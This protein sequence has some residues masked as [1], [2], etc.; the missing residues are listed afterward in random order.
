ML[1]DLSK[2]YGDCVSDEGAV[3][4][5][6]WA[7]VRWGPIV[8]PY[9]ASLHRV[10]G[11]ASHERHTLL[12]CPAP[13]RREGELCWDA[14][15]LGV[16]AV[17][18][19]RV[20]GHSETLARG[21]EGAIVWECWAPSAECRIA[22]ADGSLMAGLGYVEHIQVSIRPWQLPFDEL[23][24][25]RFVSDDEALTWI[26]WLGRPARRWVFRNGKE[27]DV[28]SVG[29]DRIDLPGDG[30]AL[31]LTDPI[32]LRD[33]RLLSGAL[34]AVPV[35]PLLLRGELRHAHET[36][37]LSRGTFTTPTRT[38][39]GWAVHESVRLRGG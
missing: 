10:P 27:L 30:G 8:L 28:A 20:P 7:R 15:R 36:K 31:E 3:F 17:W 19:P 6:Y 39:S 21:R 34:R 25:G 11:E 16:R 14:K 4:V 18:T 5:G 23:R 22:L 12:P 9:A 2:W 29:A 35:A 38:S 13:H 26:E 1:F 32:V 24:W 37:W 33:E